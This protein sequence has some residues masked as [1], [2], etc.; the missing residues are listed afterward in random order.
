[1][2]FC[3][4][5]IE[6]RFPSIVDMDTQRI[7]YQPMFDR[8]SDSLSAA[9][10]RTVQD[11]KEWTEQNY[12]D[13]NWSDYTL[14]STPR[15]MCR[16]CAKFDVSIPDMEMSAEHFGYVACSRCFRSCLKWCEYCSEGFHI[17]NM[18]NIRGSGGERI[19][20]CQPCFD[21]NV[22]HCVHCS[23]QNTSNTCYR[24]DVGVTYYSSKPTFEPM[25]KGPVWYG[26]ELE[27]EVK[28]GE[29]DNDYDERNPFIDTIA[30]RCKPLFPADY[31][32]MKEDNSL[33][34]GFEICTRPASLEYHKHALTKFLKNHPRELRSWNG[35][36][37][38]IHVHISRAPLSYLQIGKM[39][40]LIHD[41][42]DFTQRIAQRISPYGDFSGKKK[43]TDARF[44][45]EARD[46]QAR[47]EALNLTNAHTV[48]LRIFRGTLNPESFWKCI[49]FTDALV[50]FTATSVYGIKEI[51]PDN[52]IKFAL[53]H[54]KLWPNL[55][56]FLR[57]PFKPAKAVT[58]REN[59]TYRP[60]YRT[61][62]PSIQEIEQVTRRDI[63][64]DWTSRPI[65]V[66][67]FEVRDE[68]PC[69]DPG[70]SQCYPTTRPETEP[71]PAARTGRYMSNPF[72]RL[73][74]V[75]VYDVPVSEVEASP[76]PIEVR[77]SPGSMAFDATSWQWNGQILVN[78][79]E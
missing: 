6:N 10:I 31:C 34:G 12:P 73:A 24:C 15:N 67:D 39:L 74:G 75:N 38:G 16:L 37:C 1:M 2:N 9:R 28:G 62:P 4:L 51:N 27:V 22:Y 50:Q 8:G 78:D 46:G 29:H 52:F 43:I 54:S 26:I 20:C 58:Q 19:L 7:H 11:F 33:E 79:E 32:I 71:G 25:G 59:T 44:S 48:E 13:R 65:P 76:P 18:R 56:T 69:G 68:E 42:T 72:T 55:A 45:G 57:R 3:I 60:S 23:S 41:F 5:M 49:E 21:E 77:P 63:F 14:V 64:N 70:C 53:S 66:D 36:N 40:V 17:N 35:G 30:Q 47:H 61:S